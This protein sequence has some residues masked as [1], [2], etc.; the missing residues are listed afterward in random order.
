MI[1]KW[2]SAATT[3]F[4]ILFI[5]LVFAFDLA[6]PLGVAGGVPYVVVVL[7]ARWLPGIGFV[8]GFALAGTVLTMLEYHLSPSGGI[9]WMTLTNRA[10]VLFTIWACALFV[11]QGKRRDQSLKQTNARF[12]DFAETASDW[13]WEMDADLRFTYLSD[14]IDENLDRPAA[15]SIGRT[16]KDI[17]ADLIK[18]GTPEEQENWRRHFAD[19]EARRPF[20]NFLQLWITPSGE[21]RNFTNNGKP[22]FDDAGKFA[23][24]RGTASNV[25]ETVLAEQA[26]QSSLSRYRALVESGT[27]G[28]LVF[29]VDYRPIYVSKL[30][31]EIFGYSSAAEME[32]LPSFNSIL[33]EAEAERTAEN[34]RR[35]FAG[36]D[37]PPTYEIECLRKDGSTVWILQHTAVIEWEGDQAILSTITDITRQKQNEAEAARQ[38]AVTTALIDTLSAHISLRDREG[39]FVFV[40]RTMAEDHGHDVSEFVGRKLNEIRAPI[41]TSGAPT[42][43]SSLQA[44]AEEVLKTGKSIRNHMLTPPLF[45]DRTFLSDVLPLPQADGVLA[46]SQDITERVKVEKA[47]RDSE[48]QLRLIADAMP[49]LIAYIDASLRFQFIN[50]VG[51]HWYARPSAEIIGHE[52]SDVLGKDFVQARHDIFAGVLA[53]TPQSFES[54]YLYPDGHERLV[55]GNYIP[56]K[57]EDGSII[58]FY[59]LTMDVTERHALEERLRQSQKM[60]AVGQ[61]TGGIAH[62]FNN[63]LAI[64]LGNAEMLAS[65]SSRSQTAPQAIVRAAERGAKLTR[66]LLAFSRKQPLA[67]RIIDPAALVADMSEMMRR[68]LG[69]TIEITTSSDPE[70]WTAMADPGQLENALLNL[71][72]NARDAMPAGGKLTLDCRNVQ[73]QDVD[74][75]EDTYVIAG[76]YVMLAVSDTGTGMDAETRQHVFEP[77]YTTKGVGEGS[78]LGLSMVYGFAKQSGGHVDICSE[79][80]RGTTV[81]L[82]LPRAMHPAAEVEP[83]RRD[84]SPPGRGEAVLVIEDDAEVRE[85]TVAMLEAMDYRVTAVA[86]AAAA[87]NVIEG[88]VEFDLLLS[89]VVLPGGTSGPDFARELRWSEPGLKVI[90]MSGY[91]DDAAI[92]GGLLDPG[93]VLL[94][95][96]FYLRQLATAMREALG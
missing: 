8:V 75:A 32:A 67:P 72:L 6:L 47:L 37:T 63:L 64:I 31:A 45:P 96:P 70:L 35:R 78:G 26:L 22:F 34:R 1:L 14:S 76:D 53:G 88:G 10:L 92:G 87:R 55:S 19:L 73:L 25:T 54:S 3:I 62:D 82:Y 42:G 52:I 16:R 29:D 80:G 65:N 90:F 15:L 43:N 61:L 57:N 11:I 40:N 79:Q 69:V 28:M 7:L 12:R 17:F 2:S 5:A 71:A 56:H 21:Q 46:I 51:E 13:F 83:E 49:G 94:N 84:A 68:S 39:K 18:S 85:L 30:A 27:V 86:D 9:E 20:K 36:E 48:Q 91:P 58:G 33:T 74:I 89:D 66:S 23:G 93:S 59:T 41:D 24:Y 4:A 44:M 81:K 60:E 77:F 50:E 38:S 95:K